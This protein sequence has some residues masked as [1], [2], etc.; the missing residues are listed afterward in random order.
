VAEG[1]LANIGGRGSRRGPARVRGRDGGQHFAG[2]PVCLVETRGA[3]ACERAAQLGSERHLASEHERGRD[4]P[5]PG[6]RRVDH[7][8]GLRGLPEAGVGT[9]ASAGA[10]S[11][12]GQPFFSQRFLGTRAHRRERLRA[13]VSATLFARSQSHRGSVRQAQGAAAES[14]GTY[15]RGAHRGD[16]PSSRG[17]DG[18]RCSRLLQAPRLPREGPSAM[19]DAIVAHNA[20]FDIPFLMR[21]GC[22]PQRVSCTKVLSQLRWGGR[23]DVHHSLAD[24]IKRHAPDH[25]PKGDVDHAV[26]RQ[27]TIPEYALEYATNDSKPLLAI[28][29]DELRVLERVGMPE[30]TELEEKFL[31][32]VIAATDVGIPVDP[33]KWGAVIEEAVERKREL[34]EQLDGFLGDDI[35]IP[36][37]FT[38]ANTGR[39]DIGKI[40]WSSPEQK[41]WAVEALGLEVPTRWDYRKKEHRKTLDK[42]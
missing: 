42:N 9:V 31:R 18:E 30:V 22:N 2:A 8:G 36:E 39:D 13:H 27:P 20:A 10:G 33:S 26:W 24:V 11:S 15:P 35:E 12:D 16:G 34:A 28:Y 7:G 25:K 1:G 21:V 29:E 40:N 32:V 17:G 37:K 19:T 4:G 14:R 3:G 41:M 5:M 38:K 23:D 6:G